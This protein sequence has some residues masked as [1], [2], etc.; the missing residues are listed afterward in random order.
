LVATKDNPEE[1]EGWYTKGYNLAR[2]GKYDEAINAYDEAIR[3][4]PKY[5]NTWYAKVML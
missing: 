3:L 1:A 2:L 4:D 5:A